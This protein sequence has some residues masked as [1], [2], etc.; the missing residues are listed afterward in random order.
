MKCFRVVGVQ[1]LVQHSCLANHRDRTSMLPAACVLFRSFVAFVD[2]P[3]RTYR[4]AAAL[5]IPR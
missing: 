3:L 5:Q 1:A 4:V 2:V